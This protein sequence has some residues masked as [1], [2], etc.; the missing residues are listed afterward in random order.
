MPNGGWF[1]GG[2]TARRAS[3]IDLRRLE[4]EFC[5]EAARARARG[6]RRGRPLRQVAMPACPANHKANH[7]PAC[8]L[9][10]TT[11]G[12][13]IHN[14]G[15]RCGSTRMPGSFQ[16][17]TSPMCRGSTRDGALENIS[18]PEME[19][20]CLADACCQGYWSRHHKHK[21]AGRVER[22]FRPVVAWE[23]GARFTLG[24]WTATR[25][26]CTGDAASGP[27]LPAYFPPPP[28]PA[29]ILSSSLERFARAAAVANAL[30]FRSTHLAAAF[31]PPS[32]S[33]A[34]DRVTGG[35][36]RDGYN[37]VRASHRNAWGLIDAANTSMAVFED[38]IGA[39]ATNASQV[40]DFLAEATHGRYDVAFLNEVCPLDRGGGAFLS[41]AALWLTPFAARRLLKATRGCFIQRQLSRYVDPKWVSSIHYAKANLDIDKYTRAECFK[42]LRCLSA[43]VK[44]SPRRS[45]NGQVEGSFGCGFFSQERG[46]VEPWRGYN[47]STQHA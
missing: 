26:E 16:D 41:Q 37:G 12:G 2:V 6:C 11:N 15:R 31:P 7:K 39:I 35:C 5:R 30:G 14:D 38:D 28:W 33:P 19:A 17:V 13:Y 22:Y 24:A 25:K 1:I 45:R 40:R 36:P 10:K 3:D 34:W 27:I 47:A 20:R 8:T 29:L 9:T 21:K 42:S 32:E 18:T 4:A 46:V 23:E 43:P 44:R